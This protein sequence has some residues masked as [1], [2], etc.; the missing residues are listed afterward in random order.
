MR[1]RWCMEVTNMMELHQINKC[2]GKKHV[3][4]DVTVSIPDGNIYGLIG[5]NGA[6]KST[7]LR[8]IAGVYRAD[9]GSMMLDKEPVYDNADKK[10]QVLFISDEPFQFFH[11]TLKDMKNFYA[12]WY[13]LDESLYQTY[14]EQFHLDENKPLKN[15][16]KGMKRQG[17]LIIALAIAP[18]YLLLDESF[19]G[20]DPIMRREFK[21]AITARIAQKQMTVILASHDIKEMQEICDA[22]AMLQDGQI[23]TSGNLVETLSQVHR[24]K[25]AFDQLI[26]PTWFEELDLISMRVTSK[27]VNLYVRGQEPAL[28][29]Y[30]STLHPLMMEVLPVSLEELFIQKVSWKENVQ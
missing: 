9:R 26:D 28:R 1:Y 12:S 13:D 6:G 21:S 17:F 5:P 20:L 4:K 29:E 22:F 11:A 7:L 23:V 24:I 15:F 2:L 27:V 30:L 19:D 25:L 3:L 14:R 10:R 8:I 16:S 18:R